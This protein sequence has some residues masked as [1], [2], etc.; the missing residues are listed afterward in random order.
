[1]IA[2]LCKETG[3]PVYLT[4]NGE[5]D[6]VVIDIEACT[7]RESMLK[8]REHLVAVEEERLN[9]KL[10]FSIDETVSLMQKAV[11]EDISG[12]RCLMAVWQSA[13]LAAMRSGVRVSLG[14][15]REA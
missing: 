14:S 15:I 9:G 4:K 8:L 11:H 3:E 1:M 13:S 10:G 12:K 5:G 2:E 6:L 7:R